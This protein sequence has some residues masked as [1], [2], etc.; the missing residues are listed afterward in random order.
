MQR[1][2][3][4]TSS[5]VTR[6]RLTLKYNAKLGLVRS[7]RDSEGYPGPAAEVRQRLRRR[8]KGPYLGRLSGRVLE[9]QLQS[10]R[11]SADQRA[12]GVQAVTARHERLSGFVEPDL[13]SERIPLVLAHVGE[14]RHHEVKR[15]PR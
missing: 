10:A 1:S 2:K 11:S 12:D 15:T 8:Q 6:L 9:R 7:R 14:I 4:R 13:G 3:V 5:G